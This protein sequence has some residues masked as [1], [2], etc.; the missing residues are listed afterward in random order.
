MD[1]ITNY[2]KPILVRDVAVSRFMSRVYG[3]MTFGL[4]ITAIVSYVIGS[5]PALMQS[6]KGSFMFVVILQFALVIGISAGINKLSVA[7]ATLLFLVYS[8]TTGVLL[9]TLFVQYSITSL[10]QTFAITAGSFAGLAL[11]GATTKR[12]LK[13]M[14]TF[15]MMGLFGI[16]IAMVVNFFMHSSALD[17][18]ISLAGVLIFAGLT[19]WDTQ[20]IKAF[21]QSGQTETD[22][23][24]KFAILG[25][26]TLYLDFINLFLFLL[27][28]TGGRS[29]RDY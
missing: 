7:M 22:M 17:S 26:L 21:G 1:P 19:A 20:K 2:Q 16:I 5:D 25:A 4:L 24:H 15:M 28:F 9:S 18:V 3:W 8:F 14:G 6:L 27:R 13:A 12:D 29:R 10:G 11:Y 23:G